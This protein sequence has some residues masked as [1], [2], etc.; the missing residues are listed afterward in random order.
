MVATNK[1]S[2][3]PNALTKEFFFHSCFTISSSDSN[4][5]SD[6]LSEQIPL[7]C[8]NTQRIANNMR[9]ALFA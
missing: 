7:G 8:V 4:I 9:N 6:N 3:F 5:L 2:I 1:N